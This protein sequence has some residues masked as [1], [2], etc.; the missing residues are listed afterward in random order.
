MVKKYYV[1][2][3][4]ICLILL[5]FCQCTLKTLSSAEN[6]DKS[7]IILSGV[8][9]FKD[10]NF[11]LKY[12]ERGDI[13]I[14]DKSE[15]R[16]FKPLAETEIVDF[17]ILNCGG[18]LASA[19]GR[20]IKRSPTSNNYDWELELLTNT[21]AVDAAEKVKQCQSSSDSNS[22]DSK[23]FAVFRKGNRSVIKTTAT[24]GKKLFLSLPLDVQTWATEG[25]ETHNREF[26]SL[27]IKAGD[28]WADTDGD[29]EIDTVAITVNCN[30]DANTSLTC[31]R[32]L[33]WDST[34]WVEISY[35]T[36]A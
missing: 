22:F 12:M 21:I 16:K 34:G 33:R 14:S 31:R 18:F 15:I 13:S 32:L 17:D 3:F 25:N 29:G 35:F 27:S 5:S 30:G 7:N 36:P 26:A 8:V 4:S 1:S 19:K 6:N 23:A 9:Q 11:Q 24:P 10:G 2:S 20:N 28:F